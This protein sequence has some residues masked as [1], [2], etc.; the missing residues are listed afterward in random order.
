[1]YTW[2]RREERER[3]TE[4]HAKRDTVMNTLPYG[5]K[6]VKKKMFENYEKN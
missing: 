1:M 4:I 6:D 5:D 3:Q 2:T